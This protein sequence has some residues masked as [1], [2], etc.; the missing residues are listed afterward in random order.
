MSIPEVKSTFRGLKTAIQS[1]MKGKISGKDQNRQGLV[2]RVTDKRSM[3]CDRRNETWARVKGEELARNG[4]NGKNDSCWKSY[5]WM[6]DPWLPG[7]L[8]EQSLR[9]Q[10]NE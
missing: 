6:M 5:L 9:G 3:T 7:K 4:N 2:P 1:R 8:I 10:L